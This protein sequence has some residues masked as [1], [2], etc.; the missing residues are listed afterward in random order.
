M[1]GVVPGRWGSERGAIQGVAEPLAVSPNG[2][3]KPQPIPAPVANESNPAGSDGLPAREREDGLLSAAAGTVADGK[4]A[5]EKP[6]VEQP[7]VATPAFE[8]CDAP[9]ESAFAEP[10][11]GKRAVPEL[12]DAISPPG[13]E[14]VREPV[15]QG[16]PVPE[17]IS[18][19]TTAFSPEPVIPELTQPESESAL[20]LIEPEG[21]MAVPIAGHRPVNSSTTTPSFAS[22]VI[23][24]EP[25]RLQ[26]TTTTAAT[27]PISAPGYCAPA[28]PA[29]AQQFEDGMHAVGQ[30]TFSLEIASM[31]LTPTF[32]MSRLTLKP[33]SK[34]VS[35]RLAPSQD[36]QPRMKLPVTFEVVAIELAGKTIGTARLAPSAQPNPTVFSSPTFTISGIELVAGSAPVQLTPSHQERASVQLTAEFQIAAIEFTPAFE[37]ASIVLNSPS[38]TV[39]MRLPGSEPNAPENSAL[40]EIE[41]VQLGP[42]NEL[43]LVRVTPVVHEIA[44]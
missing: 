23:C 2:I 43:G 10:A 20:E 15:G 37:I 5:L 29:S 21:E 28:S 34:V 32:K 18:E 38:G 22:K 6:A 31:Q 1:A 4:A 39:S 12:A 36:S 25:L 16:Q 7:D 35:M 19:P 9:P 8:G 14:A 33:T 44:A 11:G 27:T 24:S 26:P 13:A 40:F 42:G 41:N 30:L 17:L 3:K